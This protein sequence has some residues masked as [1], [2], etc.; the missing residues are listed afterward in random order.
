MVPADG[1]RLR[2]IEVCARTGA[3]VCSAVGH[4]EVH[5][6]AGGKHLVECLRGLLGVARM[7]F[8]APVVE[9]PVPEFH[10]EQRVI[11]AVAAETGESPVRARPEIRGGRHAGDHAAGEHVVFGAVGGEKRDVDASLNE[12]LLDLFQVDEVGTKRS[13]LIFNLDHR[14][15]T[16]VCFQQRNHAGEQLIEER[17]YRCRVGCLPGPDPDTGLRG[18]PGREPAVVPFGANVRPRSQDDFESFLA[19]QSNEPFEVGS[20]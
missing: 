2:G 8:L 5:R 9:P 7:V 19:R 1:H 16:A 4:V 6:P 17:G 12:R 3:E 11:G 15:R 10:A 20:T 14:N 13:V 18:E